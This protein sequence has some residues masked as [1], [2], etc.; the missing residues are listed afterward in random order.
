M[1][2]IKVYGQTTGLRRLGRLMFMV[3]LVGL[4]V[5]ATALAGVFS[6]AAP[7]NAARAGHTATLLPNGKVLVAGGA[8]SQ[9]H[10]LA[11]AE[12]YDPASNTWSAAGNLSTARV[13]ATATL[14]PSGKVLVAGGFN[15]VDSVANADLYDP[16]NN[17]WSAAASLAS[18]R[19]FHT[20]T[21]LPNG[22]VLVAGGGNSVAG[23]LA[24][25]ELYNPTSNSWSGAGTAET[26]RDSHTA[27]LLPNGTVLVVAGSDNFG[28]LVSA[29]LYNAASNSWSAAGKLG[30]AR[31]D[32][33][34]TLLPNGGVLVVG[35]DDGG[36]NAIGSAELYN[37]ASNS[38][39]AA[40]ALGTA[41]GLHTATL[42]PDGTVLVVGGDDG[43][44]ALAN[45]ALYD[46]TS[47]SW[48]AAGTPGSAREGHTA[49]LLPNGKVLVV[50]G[51]DNTGALA[52]AELYD[53]TATALNVQ[54]LWWAAGGTEAFWGINFAHSGDRVFA[55]WY[56]YDTTGKAWWL[57]MLASK[58]A[59][60][61]YAG[62][63][64]VDI[65]P[66]FNNFIG[67]G[68]AMPVG[69]G[70]LTFS[71]ANNGT[72]HYDL[73]AGSGGS[74]VPVSQTKTLA[75]YDLFTGPQVTCAFDPAANLALATNYQDLWWAAS[76]MES[77]WGI[78]FAHQGD[79]VFLT[80]YTYDSGGAPLW[81]SALTQRVGATNVYTGNV[82]RTSG[83][84]FDSY[85]TS[86]VV[87][88]IPTVG[89]ATLTFVNGNSATFNYTTNG[90]GGLPPGVNQTKS[91]VRFPF[92]AAGGTVC[93]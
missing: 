27:T 32:H 60:S 41:R 63:I 11:S 34:A 20:A 79:S 33:T 74:P 8:D 81:L 21:L 38:W 85:R 49:T 5:P 13:F 54:G 14:L 90:N 76:G 51:G 52:S 73:N 35:G 1:R 4:V 47:N 42:L 24:S 22:N 18:A 40:S 86:D 3:A 17:S 82:L 9:T 64:Y 75:R 93:H 72:F 67:T 15:G 10:Y 46:P 61:T 12:L 44:N 77:G 80:W 55:T 45:A 43:V 87:Q 66:P 88:P 31:E 36:V 84:R 7:M 70:T 78:N 68:T 65:G 89:T 28:L 92:A 26:V 29:E 16:A 83:P 19:T 69:N 56:T 25:A 57:S 71:D 48:S 37:P 62:P 53:P 30:T 59:G 91:I 50:G 6:S 23:D 39:S 58:T 2:L